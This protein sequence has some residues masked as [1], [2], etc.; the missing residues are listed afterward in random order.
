MRTVASASLSAD[1]EKPPSLG[2]DHLLGRSELRM[3]PGLRWRSGRGGARRQVDSALLLNSV[4]SEPCVGASVGY[5]P[6]GSLISPLV[7]GR[8]GR[9]R[10]GAMLSLVGC[11]SLSEGPT[12]ERP[13]AQPLPSANSR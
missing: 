7:Y 12:G 8:S 2:M 6:V 13:R 4:V 5:R 1:G 11:W 9:V 10:F 3:G